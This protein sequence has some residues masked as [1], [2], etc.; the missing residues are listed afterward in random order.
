MDADHIRSPQ[1]RFQRHWSDAHSLLGG[2]QGGTGWMLL[3]FRMWLTGGRLRI[4]YSYCT[5]AGAG[6]AVCFYRCQSGRA[7][8]ASFVVGVGFPDDGCWRLFDYSDGGSDTDTISDAGSD[9]DAIADAGFGG[10]SGG[11]L[12]GGFG[13]KRRAGVYVLAGSD[14][15]ADLAGLAAAG[16]SPEAQACRII[17]REGRRIGGAGLGADD[18]VRVDFLVETPPF[19]RGAVDYLCVD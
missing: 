9:G 2:A 1:H 3:P 11:L 4:L 8:W 6:A 17:I 18:R 10:D 7:L 16:G 14:T 13:S 5:A 12:D 15:S 19:R